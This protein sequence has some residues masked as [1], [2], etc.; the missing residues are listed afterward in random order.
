MKL[1]VLFTGLISEKQLSGG[2]Q[3]FLDLAPRLP[4][5]I[6]LVVI[7]PRFAKN[8]WK[9]T[10]KKE[11]KFKYLKNNIFDSRKHL[12][13]IFLSYLIRTWQT[14]QILKK[15]KSIDAIYSCSDVAYADIWPAFLICQGRSEI[16]WITRIYHVLVNPTKRHGNKFV[17]F[18]AFYLQRFSFFLIKKRSNHI[19]ALNNKLKKEL[20]NLN[21]PKN[22]MGILGAGVEFRKINKF[23]A[24]EKFN[25]DAV[26][27]ARI[28]PVKGIY[29]MVK[30][31][32]LVHKSNP[33][34]K[35][36]WIGSGGGYERKLKS[37]IKENG[38]ENS[39][40]LLGYLKK[41]K[42]IN[43]FKSSKVFL[44]TDHENGWGLAISEAMAAGLPVVSFNIDIFGGLYKKGF[45][46]VPLHN[47]QKFAEETIK[48]L[49]NENLR[50]KLAK[51]AI[52][53]SSV[54][55]LDEVAKT[56]VSY[57]KLS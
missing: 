33:K 38:L 48:L 50:K 6:E 2:D 19:L 7:T 32:K 11:I 26:V 27:L 20:L 35:L 42:I 1:Y 55:D 46:S 44:C 37:K 3:L 47:T 4:K 24:T 43:I 39:F 54:F 16:K 13:F 10:E 31:W 22:R 36:A 15:A 34:W 25:F 40:C 56:L 53:Q 29:D 45:I 5:K 17:N 14:Y 23:K 28:A 49:D 21:F 9:S 57:L 30:I 41:E 18:T 52:L 8:H 12:V 51:A